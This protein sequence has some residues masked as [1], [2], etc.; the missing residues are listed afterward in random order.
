MPFCGVSDPSQWSCLTEAEGMGPGASLSPSFTWEA[1]C[2]CPLPISLSWLWA[3]WPVLS[4]AVLLPSWVKENLIPCLTRLMILLQI[5]RI[6]EHCTSHAVSEMGVVVRCKQ[7]RNLQEIEQ[8]PGAFEA[9]PCSE[10]LAMTVF[11][12]PWSSETS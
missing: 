12:G 8:T 11:E 5:I 7:G 1:K 2:W 4:P 3:Q 6:I 9:F 10:L